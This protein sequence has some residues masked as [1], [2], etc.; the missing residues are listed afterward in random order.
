M[1]TCSKC[2]EEKSLCE[3]SLNRGVP[4]SVC[5]PCR[6]S[7]ARRYVECNRKSATDYK[8]EWFQKNKARLRTKRRDEVY[9]GTRQRINTEWKAQDRRNLGR[10]YVTDK[11]KRLGFESEHI[12]PDLIEVERALIKLKRELRT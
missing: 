7:E 5:K 8:A 2:G 12:T 6:V 10:S 4:R 3:F 9:G 1:K 11:L